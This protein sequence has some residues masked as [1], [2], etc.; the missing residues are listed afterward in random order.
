MR[1]HYTHHS[2]LTNTRSA[3]TF[4][5]RF[6]WFCDFVLTP[7]WG[8]FLATVF[9]H[10]SDTFSTLLEHFKNRRNE[11]ALSEEFFYNYF[12][13]KDGRKLHSSFSFDTST[14]DMEGKGRIRRP[15]TVPER[16]SCK[17]LEEG[18]GQ[19]RRPKTK[20]ERTSCKP[21]E[22]GNGQKRRPKTVF[23]NCT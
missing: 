11:G 8:H 2:S 3:V 13:Q 21:L 12:N 10:F 19:K 16:T 7:L 20:L 22:E 5:W 15:K 17:P 6:W 1:P 18:K 14:E 9:L 23:W 4:S